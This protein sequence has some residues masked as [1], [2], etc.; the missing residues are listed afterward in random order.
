MDADGDPAIIQRLD[1]AGLVYMGAQDVQ[2]YPA[3]LSAVYLLGQLDT[4]TNRRELTEKDV[5]SLAAIG[6][7]S[8][9][10]QATQLN[11]GQVSGQGCTKGSEPGNTNE[12]SGMED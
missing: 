10:Q 1:E 11:L 6:N 9:R 3:L 2:R 8:I 12:T 5:E 4:L 7:D